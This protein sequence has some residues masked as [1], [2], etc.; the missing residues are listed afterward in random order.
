MI[1]LNLLPDVKLEYIKAQ[2]H[3]RLVI[4]ISVLASVVAAALL[5]LLYSVNLLQKHHLS[6]L[7][8]DIA[9]ESSQLRNK[10]DI[11]KILTVQNQLKSLTALHSAKP[12][13]SRLF[14]DLNSV[15]PAQVSISSFEIDFTKQTVTLT[16]ASD[17]LSSVNKYVD[18]LKFTTYTTADKT[19]AANAF[20]NVVLAGF[21]LAGNS[22][23][24]AHAASY[25]ITLAY[26]PPIFDIT[27]TVKLSVPNQVTTRSELNQASN[28]FQASNNAPA[29][30]G[31]Q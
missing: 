12:A 6:D 16:G 25:S 28:L 5:I 27:K 4:G 17:S 3:R 19:P 23:D 11:N 22:Q 21:S 2:S 18:T 30:T 24:A 9:T 13:A 10:P 7:N 20:K 29:T 31:G 26:D 8:R 15:T 1:Q 14:D